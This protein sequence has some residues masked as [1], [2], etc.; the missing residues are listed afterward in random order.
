MSI[1]N[2]RIGGRLYG[3]FGTLVLFGAV[4]AG[5]GV[6]Q[7][8]GIQTDVEA[9]TVQSQN[10]IRVGQISSELQAARR[11]I[12]R[13]QFDHD[14]P[15]YAEAEKR[16][17]DTDNLLDESVKST[18]S[19]DRR[20]LYRGMKKDIAELKAK[21]AELGVVVKQYLAGKDALFTDGDKMAA[22]VQKFV[23]ATKDTA[24]SQAANSLE[25]KLLLVRVANWRTLA[26]RDPKGRD[27]FKTNTGKAQAEIAELEKSDL[28][29]NLAAL[30]TPVKAGV[31]KYA[32]AFE[33]ASVGLLAGDEI[34][35]K[36][37][38]PAIVN[39]VKQ[40]E[41]AK[42]SI[43]QVFAST[44]AEVKSSISG[45]VTM[46]EIVSGIAAL[47]GALVAF[48]IARSIT[49]PLAE[50]VSDSTRLSGGDTSAKFDAAQRSDEI[51]K[52]AGAVANS[53]TTSSPSRRPPNPSKRRSRRAR[54][55]PA[56]W[57]ARSRRSA[58][59]PT[60]CS[61]RSAKTPGS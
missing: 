21:R 2:L 44:T 49:R 19:E 43:Q 56:T 47:F 45:T 31:A 35:Y 46:Q 14:E 61:R 37:V 34:Y 10:A 5:F 3:G 36:G 33:K 59:P 38:T 24:F 11:A 51:G 20:N 58:S 28:P 60:N 12:L 16:L 52:V 27:T 25:A 7:L 50:L 41:S 22:D 13:Y 42:T 9:M 17:T 15:S 39:A 54:R 18:I 23:D 29:P 4:L 1:F 8:W 57:T 30:M 53:A 48:F 55:S 26:T 6:S 32:E 40:I